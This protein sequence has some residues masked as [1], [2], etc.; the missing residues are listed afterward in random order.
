MNDDQKI[1]IVK[2]IQQELELRQL[3]PI[4]LVTIDG[5]PCFWPEFIENF[6]SKIHLKHTFNDNI[7]M[8]RLL[9]VLKGE[10]KR[11][12][13]SVGARGL[14]YTANSQSSSIQIFSLR[15]SK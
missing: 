3:P 10:A 5:N 2:A 12:I 8:V 15:F 13:E 4:Y 11:S 9:S 7:R 6:K 1:S 14:C